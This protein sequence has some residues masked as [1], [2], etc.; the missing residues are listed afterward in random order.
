ME[1]PIISNLKTDTKHPLVRTW[2]IIKRVVLYTVSILL[3]LVVLALA[4]AF[5]YEDE[6]KNK[7][8]SELNKH[9]KTE[10]RIDP[11]TLI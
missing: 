10:V 1:E 6:V 3:A 11:K 9:L 4:L 8:I 2:R 5:I 7:I